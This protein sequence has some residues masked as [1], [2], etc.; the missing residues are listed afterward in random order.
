MVASF[1]GAR[2]VLKGHSLA[3]AAG[4]D[5]NILLLIRESAPEEQDQDED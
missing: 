4:S 2:R 3:D 1:V 5:E